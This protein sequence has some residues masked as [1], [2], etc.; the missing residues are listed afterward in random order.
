VATTSTV[1]YGAVQNHVRQVVVLAF[2]RMQILDVIGPAEVLDAATQALRG[3]GG[4]AVRVATRD[5]RPVRGSSGIRIDADLALSS[6]RAREVDTLIVGGGMQF[7]HLLGVAGLGRDIARVAR[8]ARRTCSVCTGAFLLADAGLL[9]GRAATTH[10]AFCAA[11]AARHPRVRIL[12]DRIFVRDGPVMTSAGVTAGMDLALALI[13]E[14]HG[15]E[16]AR[17]VA[18]WTVMFVQ[19]PGGQSQF[20]ERLAVPASVSAPLRAVLDAVAADA[21]GDH[22]LAAMADRAAMS[23]RHFRRVFA[24]QT[25]TTPARYVERVRVEAARHQLE[26]GAGSMELVATSC[27]FGSPET[28][29]RAFLRVVGVGPAEYRLRFRSTALAA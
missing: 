14:D 12:P 3:R 22:R 4:Y 23:E 15:A 1:E 27:G 5:G 17:T 16:L 29:R 25:G 13:E 19:R 11:L 26:G 6:V 24:Q 18:R 20:S 28:M 9:D 7:D 10:W 21:A 2:D 8:G